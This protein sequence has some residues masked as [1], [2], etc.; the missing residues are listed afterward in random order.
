MRYF[1]FECH[2]A[3]PLPFQNIHGYEAT[4]ELDLCHSAAH[5]GP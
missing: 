3:D 1:L 5:Q 4:A 2:A